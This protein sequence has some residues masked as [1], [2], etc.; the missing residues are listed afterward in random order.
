MASGQPPPRVLQDLAILYGIAAGEPYVTTPLFA[1]G[2][3]EAAGLDPLAMSVDQALWV[4]I[5]APALE[6]REAALAALDNQPA[7]LNV[8][9]VPRLAPADP[10]A[11]PPDLAD[12]WQWEASTRPRR[13]D[14]PVGFTALEVE[15]D[16]T[17]GFARPGTLRLLLPPRDAVFAPADDVRADFRA[18]VG[19]RPPRLDDADLQARLLFWL[20]LR[21]AGG[22]DALPLAWLGVNVVEIDQRRTLRDMIVGA[23]AGFA[24][25]EVA[26]PGRSIDASS[27]LLEVEESG[28]GFVRWP[29]VADLAPLSPDA[30]GFELDAEAG[31]VRFGDGVRGRVPETGA[32]IAARFM[33]YGGGAAGNLPPGA[34]TGIAVGGLTAT[35][36]APLTGGAEAE[37]RST[38]RCDESPR[39][40]A[41]PSAAS[42]RRTIGTWLWRPPEPISGGSRFCRAFAR[43]NAAWASTALSRSWSCL[44]PTSQRPLTHA[45]AGS[46]SSRSGKSWSPAARS[47]LS[48]S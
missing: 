1:N 29:R 18:G 48:C 11:P 35:N 8:G 26:L 20:R 45:Q 15:Q 46:W 30:R 10:E 4:A 47:P 6:T 36:P 3:Y 22:G 37:N 42:P 38:R 21:P 43:F 34:V 9:F 32:G 13:P 41:M 5:L 44:A 19:P 12:L 16:S 28:R 17:G 24:A 31:V 39:C 27:L 14:D 7:L 2:Q 23:G 40:C 33:R 25:Q